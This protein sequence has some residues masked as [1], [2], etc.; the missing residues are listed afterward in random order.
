MKTCLSILTITFAR[1]VLWWSLLLV[2]ASLYSP[3]ASAQSKQWDKTYGGSHADALSVVKPTKDGGYILG[4]SSSSGQS[5]HKSHPNQGACTPT[6]CTQDYWIVKL[7]SAG[8]TLWDK[9][10][11]GSG[12]DFLNALAITGDGGYLLGGYSSS[13]ASGD[14]TG[15]NRGSYDYWVVK[16]DSAGNKQWDKTLGSNEADVLTSLQPCPDGGYLLGGSS[17][18]AR[19]D[20]KSQGPRGNNDFWIVKIDSAGNKQWDKTL[21]GE[22]RDLLVALQLTGDGGY[23]LGGYSSSGPGADKSEPIRGSFDYWVVKV[24]SAGNK[25]WDRTYGGNKTDILAA[26]ERSSTGGYLLGGYSPSDESG[27]KSQGHQGDNDF[28]VVELDAAGNKRWDK[29]LGGSKQDLLTAVHPTA[30]GGYLL[31]GSS[32]SGAGGDKNQGTQ[33]AEDQWVVKLDA[34]GNKQWDR[35]FGGK[36]SDELSSL[37]QTTDGGYILGGSSESEAGGDKS[38][39]SQGL[40][41]YWLVKIA[42]DLVPVLPHFSAFTPKKGVPGSQVTITGRNLK[43]LTAVLFN[44]LEADFEVIEDG[45]VLAMVPVKATSGK[46]SLVNA[47][48]AVH[49]NGSYLVRHPAI[50]LVLPFQ[51]HV[52][53]NVLLLG[54]RLSTVSEV[55]FNGVPAQDFAVHADWVVTAVV[56]EGATTG[57]IK[58][59]LAGG[60]YGVSKSVF[61]VLEG[62]DSTWTGESGARMAMTAE[63]SRAIPEVP[64]TGVY[65][66]PFRQQ[67]TFRFTL[68]QRQQVQV[69]VYDLLGRQLE[70][71]Y[72]G[73]V[74]PHQPYLLEWRPRA[75]LAAGL[76]IIRLEAPGQVLQHKVML[77]R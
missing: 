47:G 53:S 65:P 72:Q 24:D 75:Q 46:I 27:D 33:G 23:I 57:K 28:W 16:I 35:T 68:P 21:G 26:L 3:M 4:G 13:D 38:Q 42:G 74:R 73:E 6:L 71:L 60:G 8:N 37:H 39:A 19:N 54:D 14:K 44:G 52:G 31:G 66:N 43:G 59:V 25:L 45:L 63:A 41:D 48:G 30:D 12:S 9:T 70:L 50:S 40:T 77:S 15:A 36:A 20:D 55:Y 32:T 29:T 10:F 58:V 22:Q 11:G 34:A 76:Y 62:S 49:S 69:K 1:P 7:D 56:P 18:S 61:T 64:P 2:A 17:P 5:G 67:V 51:G